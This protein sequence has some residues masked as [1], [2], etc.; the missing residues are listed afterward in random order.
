MIL[1]GIDVPIASLRD[2]FASRL[3]PDVANK[4]YYARVFKNLS[5]QNDIIG[6]VFIS[7]KEYKEVQFDDRMD[8]V[9]FFDVSD[10]I[11]NIGPSEQTTRNV[12]IVFAVNIPKIYPAIAYRAT[13]ELYRDVL[14]VINT[15]HSLSVTPIDIIGG[16]NAYGELSTERLVQFNMQPWHVFR[17]N[18]VM[19]IGYECGTTVLNDAILAF[20]YQ[21]P[22]IF[23]T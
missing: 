22:I 16:L 3:W 2:A 17:V 11:E 18:T 12:G 5:K 14:Y 10:E 8:L 6:E 4:T 19:N 20:P 21:F 7:D 13:E 23:R 15:T 9:S 1:T